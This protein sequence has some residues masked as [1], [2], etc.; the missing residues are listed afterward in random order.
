MSSVSEFQQNSLKP[1]LK[2]AD[3]NTKLKNNPHRVWVFDLPAGHS[4]PGAAAC[5]A[6]ADRETG[7]ILDGAKQ[8]FRCYAASQEAA[9]SNVRQKRWEHFSALR[10]LNR[11]GMAELILR[12]MPEKALHVRV[13]SSGDFFSQAYFDAWMDVARAR[14]AVLFYAYTKSLKF[15]RDTKDGVPENFKLVASLGGKFDYLIDKLGLPRVFVVAH[16]EVAEDLGLEIDHDDT[17]AMRADGDFALLIHGAQASGSEMS[18]AQKRLRD[19]GIK[20]GYK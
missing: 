5:Q 7:R 20:Y 12:D 15:V 19:E 1:S 9:F 6:F 18:L 17:H 11:A 13:H 16:P 3:G 8:Q 14:P 10:K 2:F 4:C